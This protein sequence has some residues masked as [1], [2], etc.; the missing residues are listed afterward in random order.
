MDGFVPTPQQQDL[1]RL[2][3]GHSDFYPQL[4]ESGIFSM[5]NLQSESPSLRPFS[6]KN[7]TK[8]IKHLAFSLSYILII[9]V[10]GRYRQGNPVIEDLYLDELLRMSSNIKYP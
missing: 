10:G 5:A 1:Q 8:K 6:R 9:Y 7:I 2:V 4:G 3:Q